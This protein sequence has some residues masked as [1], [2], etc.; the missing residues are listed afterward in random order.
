MKI[1][2]DSGS[3]KT[4]WVLLFDNGQ[5][6]SFYSQG[7]NPY[8]IEANAIHDIVIS[9]FS[10][11]DVE[12]VEAVFFYGAGCALS[13]KCDIVQQGLS[14]VFTMAKIN[15]Y[16]DLLASAHALFGRM[17]GVACILGT[18][19]NVAVYN[20]SLFT[21][22]IKSVGYLLGDEGS[23]SYIGKQ[24]LQSFL[25]KEMPTVLSEKFSALFSIDLASVLNNVYKKPFPNRYL[26]SFTSFAG[27]YHEHN[28]IQN[29]IRNSFRDFIRY[30]LNTLDFDKQTGL[31]FVG[32]IAFYFQDILK[33]ELESEGYK[34]VLIIKEPIHNLVAFHK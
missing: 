21:S 16:S 9:C 12:L 23:G 19:S 22:Q 29:I 24:L 28:F 32:S 18:G 14:S 13:E 6:Q 11:L 15:T 33:E 4:H 1:I 2:A 26:A 27:E 31:G 34:P 7:I 30:Q 8:F 5:Q 25:R 3:T 20:G 10:E 17:P